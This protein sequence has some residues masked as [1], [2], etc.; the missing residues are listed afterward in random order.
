MRLRQIGERASVVGPSWAWEEL[1]TDGEVAAIG[2]HM[3]LDQTGEQ[4]GQ[5]FVDGCALARLGEVGLAAQDGVR[6]L[7]GDD[8]EG[9]AERRDAA[10]VAIA[11]EQALAVE[12][13]P[14]YDLGGGGGVARP[15]AASR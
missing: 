9:R 1:F 4:V 6:V 3:L 11:E 5:S 13:G 12:A 2:A 15:G 8:V 10:S 7:V 14:A